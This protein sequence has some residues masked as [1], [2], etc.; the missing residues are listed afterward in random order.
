VQ[1]SSYIFVEEDL[2]LDT[3]A[4]NVS[5]R[6]EVDRP[7]YYYPYKGEW[8]LPLPPNTNLESVKAVDNFGNVEFKIEENFIYLYNSKRI[9][10]GEIY[11]F[12]V[13][14]NQKYNPVSYD[15][16][17]YFQS[18]YPLKIVA[19]KIFLKLPLE[20]KN[21]R[22]VDEDKLGLKILN[23]NPYIM[24]LTSN[25]TIYP[26]IIFWLDH[27]E[28][29]KIRQEYEHF[30]VYLPE[31]YNERFRPV[32]VKVNN[33][34]YDFE[35][36]FNKKI[37]KLTITFIPYSGIKGDELC[38]YYHENNSITCGIHLFSQEEKDIA[39]AVNHEITH[40]FTSHAFGLGLPPWFDEGLA[41]TLGFHF[42]EIMGYNFTG[43]YAYK[44]E[45]INTCKN[46]LYNDLWDYWECERFSKWL[47][48]IVVIPPNECFNKY[49]TNDIRYTFSWH[50]VNNEIIKNIGIDK[51]TYLANYFQKNGI[52]IDV[53]SDNKNSI[54]ALMFFIASKNDFSKI[55]NDT[56]KIK[57]EPAWKDSYQNFKNAEDQILNLIRTSDFDYYKKARGVLQ[58]SLLLS[59]NGKFNESITKALES[60]R[61][62][63]EI[64]KTANETKQQITNANQTILKLK[65]NA[66]FL[67][68]YEYPESLLLDAYE[69][70]KVG[71]FEI[72]ML[73]IR[74]ALNKSEEISISLNSFIE[75]FTTLSNKINATL[76]LYQ[77]FISEAKRKLEN[78]W[79]LFSECKLES[80]Q[81][82][83][84][85]VEGE[86]RNSMIIA[87][88][89]Y[90]SV[91]SIIVIVVVTYFYRKKR[92]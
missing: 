71:N 77:P 78:S 59:F 92:F 87:N 55:L 28:E 48:P 53:D 9:N 47:C 75:Q 58:S 19:D 4:Y 17:F 80:A 40:A 51:I 73:K 22:I 38:G 5:W 69:D 32:I 33:I 88:V 61:I 64:K 30:N 60:I 15:N 79:S 67:C 83:L 36:L 84:S 74:N 2:A 31:K 20:T 85:Q 46:A 18:G 12:N 45:L 63:E 68:M 25:E 49:T 34:L 54:V 52:T 41:E 35:N 82:T 27:F 6:I 72:S 86:I 89:L 23:T 62:A 14:F 91:C 37:S 10:Y 7:G 44:K 43:T 24:E 76:F 42:S 65:D 70:Y 11:Y 26:K 21:Y 39:Q 8:G 13:S 57:I 56:Y 66:P 16:E 3:T 1:A 50:I 29:T 81:K 90:V